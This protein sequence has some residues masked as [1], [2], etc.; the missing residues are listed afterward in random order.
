MLVAYN[1]GKKKGKKMTF[2][3]TYYNYVMCMFY[4]HTAPSILQQ[5]LYSSLSFNPHV[6]CHNLL[7]PSRESLLITYPLPILIFHFLSAINLQL[8]G[9][10]LIPDMNQSWYFII[11][12]LPTSTFHSLY[13]MQY[14]W[15]HNTL[16]SPVTWWPLLECEQDINNN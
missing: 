7:L 8:S 1:L 5:E 12:S 4:H 14:P 16:L 6:T 15:T 11:P 3:C 10:Q 13:I 9:T 2:Q